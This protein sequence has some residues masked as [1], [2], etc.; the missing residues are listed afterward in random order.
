MNLKSLTL[1]ELASLF[2]ELGEPGFRATPYLL[3]L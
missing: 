2:K 1:T 3:S